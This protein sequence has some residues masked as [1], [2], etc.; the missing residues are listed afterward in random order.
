M[1]TPR[2]E[3]AG[4]ALIDTLPAGCPLRERDVV[5]ALTA[6]Q[7]QS[8]RLYVDGALFGDGDLCRRARLAKEKY[9]TC[10]N[11]WGSPRSAPIRRK[12]LAEA[13]LKE[14]HERR[15]TPNRRGIRGEVIA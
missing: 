11:C 12:L 9:E 8:H 1:I 3:V 14:A 2:C 15:K 10:F 13:D 5:G 6:L 4:T 7:Q